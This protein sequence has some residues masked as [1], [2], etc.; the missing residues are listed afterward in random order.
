MKEV[1]FMM[2]ITPEEIH[3]LAAE[4]KLKITQEELP[5]IIQY[6]NEFLTEIE[7]MNELDLENVPL[8][9]FSEPD[10][11]PMREDNIVK[12][13][14]RNDILTAAPNRDG[15]YYRVARILEE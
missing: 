4:A 14:Y 5:G 15:D 6:M 1:E 10:S 11:C 2:P 7:R 3:F 8:F 13:P 9:G 12:Y